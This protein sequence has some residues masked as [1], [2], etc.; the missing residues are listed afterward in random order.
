LAGLA[1]S[2]TLAGTV[3]FLGEGENLNA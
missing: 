1:I 3:E 2:D